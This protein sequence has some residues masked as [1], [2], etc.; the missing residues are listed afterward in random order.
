MRALRLVSAR[1]RRVV[2]GLLTCSL[3]TAAVAGTATAGA[4][5]DVPDEYA[6]LEPSFVDQMHLPGAMMSTS[7]PK[8]LKSANVSSLS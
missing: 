7:P 3:A 5:I 6:Y 2:I 1:R 4:A 8:L